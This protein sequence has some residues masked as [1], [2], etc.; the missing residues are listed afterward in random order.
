MNAFNS[1]GKRTPKLYGEAQVTGREQFSSDISVPH[2]LHA[3]ILRSLHSHAKVISID[4]AAAESAGT[5]CI[6]FKDVPQVKFNPRLV[7]T[8]ETTYKDW[9]VL[10]GEPVYF[11]EPIAAVA[12]ETEEEA[13]RALELI[14]VEYEVLEA[15]FEASEAVKPGCPAVHQKILLDEKELTVENNLACKLEF[16]EGSVDRGFNEA[17]IVLERKYRTNRRY[18]A[19][20]ETKSVVCKPEANGGVT[21]WSTTQTIHNSRILIHDVFSIPMHKINL[22]KVALGGSFGS[23]IHTNISTLI[24]VA[25]ALK[26]GRPVKISLTREEDM[27]DH[28]SFQMVFRIKAG[29]K[30][31]GTLTAGELE[32]LM[33]IGSHQIQAYPLL[34]CVF[35]WWASFYKWRN[36][37]YVGKAV[38]TNKVPSCAMRGYGNP[39][40]SWMVE[41]FMDEMAEALGMDPI[42]L[43]TKNYIGLGEVFWGQGPTVKSVIR[44]CGVEEMLIKG[45]EMIGWK[46]RHKAGEG[47]RILRRGIGLARGFHTSSAGAP[48]TGSVIDYSGATVKLNEDGTVDVVTA[49]MDQGGGAYHAIAKIVAEELGIPSENVS[50]VQADTQTTVYDVCTHASRGIYAGGGAALNAAKQVKEKLLFYAAKILEVKQDALKIRPDT[51]LGQGVIHVEGF[52]G[53]SITVGEVAAH[54]RT[55]NWG[56]IAATISYRPTAS[57]PHFTTYF[58]EV[59]IDT[60]T[61]MVTPVR[62]VAGADIG[63]VVNPELSAGQ[64]QGGFAMG[65]SMALLEDTPYDQQTGDL[66][67]KGMLVDYKLPTSRDVPP[68]ENFE[69]FFADTYEPTGPFGA[70]GLGE[71]SYNPVAGAIANAIYNAIGIRFYELPIT[72]ERILAALNERKLRKEE[73]AIV[74]S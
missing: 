22:K 13:Q 4:T 6:T 56:S 70:K 58:V 15:V 74:T 57:P 52:P 26:A 63:T 31:D 1:I 21:L 7:S 43:K 69:V 33:D 62:V 17:D 10:T 20:L 19:Q 59:E 9:T 12:A 67:N 73:E 8:P 65:W 46:S 53:K 34:G 11:G 28:S 24:A 42:V 32:M 27:H 14:K 23:S 61:G 44:S 47:G 18:H 66:A 72:P 48:I 41:T 36:V 30:K 68:L 55:R 2:M 45:A 51:A 39:Q 64:I 40:T 38:Y 60:E 5:V 35:G 71:G 29:V 49:L 3:R 16:T 54:A 37:R 25:L 50:V